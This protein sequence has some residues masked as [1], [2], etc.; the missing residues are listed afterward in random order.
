V[1]TAGFVRS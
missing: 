1:F